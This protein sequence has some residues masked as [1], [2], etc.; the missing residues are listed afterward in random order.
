MQI[1]PIF[2]AT[3]CIFSS[4]TDN[5]FM[6]LFNRVGFWKVSLKIRNRHGCCNHLASFLGMLVSSARF[7][8]ESLEAF[9]AK[10]PQ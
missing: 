2:S 5:V 10:H 4:R 6:F 3:F 8:C 7:V 9:F 1:A